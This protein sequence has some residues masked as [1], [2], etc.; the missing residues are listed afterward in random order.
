[1]PFYA[2]PN[3]GLLRGV[4]GGKRGDETGALS[5]SK[6]SVAPNVIQIDAL[7]LMCYNRVPIEQPVLAN[8][9]AWQF[10]SL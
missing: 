3:L 7:E 1:M 5:V 4:V 2:S 6:L 8:A 10:C 9:Q